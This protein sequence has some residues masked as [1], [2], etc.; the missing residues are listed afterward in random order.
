MT[1][2][3]SVLLSI[4]GLDLG[5]T[6]K[7]SHRPLEIL[8]TF[9]LRAVCNKENAAYCQQLALPYGQKY[10]KSLGAPNQRT[11]GHW[12]TVTLDTQ[13]HPPHHKQEVGCVMVMANPPDLSHGKKGSCSHIHRE[14]GEVLWLQR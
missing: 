5:Y 14:S 2:R 13:P 11:D 9:A 3:T 7:C 4:L 1:L 10:Y 6:V 8:S 12:L